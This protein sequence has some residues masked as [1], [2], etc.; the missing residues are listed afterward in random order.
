MSDLQLAEQLNTPEKVLA[1]TDCDYFP[2]I[3]TLIM[4]VATLPVTS[5]ECERSISMLKRVK[6][7]LRSTMVEERLNGLAISPRRTSH[8]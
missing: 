2:N 7:P 4:I 1:H 3:R 6:T 8:C 5:C